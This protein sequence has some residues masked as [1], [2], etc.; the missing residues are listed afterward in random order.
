MRVLILLMLLFFTNTY[1]KTFTLQEA[2][3]YIIVYQLYLCAESP[4]TVCYYTV[5]ESVFIQYG[6]YFNNRSELISSCM[7]LCNKQLDTAPTLQKIYDECLKGYY[8][9][10]WFKR[11]KIK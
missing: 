7:K 8:F 9:S 5:K 3:K 1:P 10:D 2:C 6:S 4:D 11:N